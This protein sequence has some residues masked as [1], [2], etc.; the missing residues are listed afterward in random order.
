MVFSAWKKEEI[1]KVIPLQINFSP[2]WWHR[3]YGITFS[4]DYYFN[5]R[6]RMKT[7]GEMKRLVYER[8]RKNIRIGEERTVP[9]PQVDFGVTLLAGIFGCK[10]S[11]Y[12][13]QFPWPEPLN[14]NLED[15]EHLRIPSLQKSPIFGELL[16]QVKYLK[17]KYGK[18]VRIGWGDQG[19]LNVASQIRGQRIYT[20]FYENP[21][22]LYN[23]FT[24]ITKTII[25][26][27][28]YIRKESEGSG[29]IFTIGNCTVT[30]ISPSTYEEHLLSFDKYLAETFQPCGIHH[31]N[32]MENYLSVYSK[33]HPK[34]TEIQRCLEVG[35]DPSCIKEIRASF[36]QATIAVFVNALWLSQSDTTSIYDTIHTITSCGTPKEKLC[37]TVADID[38]DM[39]DENL[40]VLCDAVR[41][42]G[43]RNS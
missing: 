17:N 39:S 19:V 4:K 27:V 31:H 32:R 8:F 22:M 2:D 38:A 37:L 20:D 28:K 23:L 29:E 25:K 15:I 21:C 40:Q 3:N 35:E 10:I 33:I 41:K 42:Y 1:D 26:T 12:D 36:S 14:L 30:N 43:K 5:P 6:L 18:K 16:R 24:V 7:Q 11:F 34:L 9:E 13:N